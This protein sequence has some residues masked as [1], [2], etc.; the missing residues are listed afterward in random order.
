MATSVTIIGAGLGGLTLARVLHLHGIPVTVFESDA[1]ANSRTQGGQLDL[2]EHNGQL[3]LGMAGLS[4]EYRS[5][6]HAGGAAQRVVDRHGNVLVEL[7]DD[8]SMKSPEALRGDIRRI[9][10]DSL[11]P[12]TVQWGKKLRSANPLGQ[13]RHSLSFADGT[14]AVSDLLV[15]ADGTW[16]RVR[17]L[18][19]G[20]QPA[21]AGMSY[22]ETYL[23][24]VDERHPAAAALV[25]QGA[26]YA[27]TPG[28]GFLAHREANGTIHTYVVLNRP[29]E[30]FAAIDFTDAGAA[31]ARIAAE[32]DGWS[33][34]LGSLVTDAEGGPVL[35]SIYRLPNRHR[36]ERLPGVTLIGDAAHVTLPGGEG[37]NLAMLDGA[38]LGE[39][40]A[41]Q[42]DNPETAL[43]AFEAVM[44]RRSEEEAAAAQE[45]IE[46]IF[47]A[48]APEA[49]ARLFNGD[50]EPA[51]G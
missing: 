28:Q 12:G 47:G 5:I 23:H 35:R 10:L 16:S 32:F 24:G 42:P 1:A 8:G 46:L 2:H 33:P 51:A 34:V 15:G 37:A 13:G 44:F 19:S 9:L 21:Y 20:Q 43:A 50:S 26:M 39:A 45:T 18:L 49:L 38:E 25:G 7:P 6:L 17:T 11:P 3:A 29:Q 27:L 41:S 36:W 48:E 40:L 4:Q 14:A 30:W 31:K 22:V